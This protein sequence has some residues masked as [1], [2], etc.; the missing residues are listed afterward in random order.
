M[1]TDAI[2]GL[3]VALFAWLILNTI[4]PQLVTRGL[5]G[6]SL[7]PVT[8]TDK[9]SLASNQKYCLS[10]SLEEFGADPLCY[11]SL[12][13][14]KDSPNNYNASS[15]CDLTTIV[16]TSVVDPE[17]DRFRDPLESVEYCYSSGELIQRPTCVS[18]YSDCQAQSGGKPCSIRSTDPSVYITS[19]LVSEHQKHMDV[20]QALNALGITVNDNFPRTSLADL[21]DK[22]IDNL[23]R[24]KTACPACE[25]HVTGGTEPGHQT[26]GPGENAVDLRI[27]S[28][29]GAYIVQ[30]SA[31]QEELDNGFYRYTFPPGHVLNG[32]D[33]VYEK[34][35][36]GGSHWHIKWN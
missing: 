5:S 24:I 11:D 23:S 28:S 27:T 19:D 4:N 15:T 22:T 17:S 14:C 8:S 29:L 13:E 3:L 35:A 21:P 16:D 20:V 9:K 1:I 2:L 30:E 12:E 31:T 6:L 26:H 36:S 32:A 25:L 33:V 10:G 34:N 18:S 7:D